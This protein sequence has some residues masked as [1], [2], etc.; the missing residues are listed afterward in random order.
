M[1]KLMLLAGMAALLM[2]TGCIGYNAPVVPPVGLLFENVSAP[3]DADMNVTQVHQKKGTAGSISILWL[4]AFGDCSTNAA[5]R[6]GNV[7]TIHY[8][9]YSYMNVIGVYQSFKVSVYGE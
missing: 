3:L 4:F 1:K 9:D 8:A 6:D 5:A 7:Q 2:S